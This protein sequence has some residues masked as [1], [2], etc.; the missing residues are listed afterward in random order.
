[1]SNSPVKRT[2]LCENI[3]W[4]R[5]VDV[6]AD[7]VPVYAKKLLCHDGPMTRAK[8]GKVLYYAHNGDILLCRHGYG[9]LG[10]DEMLGRNPSKDGYLYV[11]PRGYV[12]VDPKDFPYGV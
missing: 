11:Y 3:N 9:M 2:P 4:R 8:T 5:Y 1:M 12:K 6:I 7:K 10:G